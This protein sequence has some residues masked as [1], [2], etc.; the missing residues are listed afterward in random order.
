MG[1]SP[2]TSRTW[3]DAF[4]FVTPEYNHGMIA[5]LKNALDFL[6]EEWAHKPAGFVGYGGVSAG[7]RSVAQA[8]QVV[9]AL[10]MLPLFENVSI[11]FVKQLLDED[12]RLV[13]TASMERAAGVLLDAVHRSA[14]ALLSLRS[15]RV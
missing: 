14:E 4:V 13:P 10:R 6:H 7:T 8:K 3:R 11:P 9:A 5:P 2:S 12:G 15:A 1:R